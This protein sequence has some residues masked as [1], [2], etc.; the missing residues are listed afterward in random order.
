MIENELRASNICF[1]RVNARRGTLEG[2]ECLHSTQKC[3]GM[4]GCQLSHLDAL[5]L[6]IL[7][8]WPYVAIFEDDFSWSSE[9]DPML[10]S[11]GIRSLMSM[12]DWDVIAISLS[13]VDY[14]EL[15]PGITYEIG[16]FKTRVIQLHDAKATHA[17]VVNKHY[18]PRMRDVF[19][20]CNTP[21]Q[22]IDNCWR[23]M[24]KTGSWFGFFPQLGSQLPGY[25]DIELRQTN[26]TLDHT[27]RGL[28]GW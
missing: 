2:K 18:V 9:L 25:S 26:Y 28:M 11:A 19:E 12:V 3:I 16:N 17:Y 7:H 14:T 5:D 21:T 24:Q 27:T 15:Q 8:K 6:A 23:K 13:I 1:S 4:V 20:S 22:S 10:I